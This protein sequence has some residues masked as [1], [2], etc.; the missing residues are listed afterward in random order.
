MGTAKGT[1]MIIGGIILL[2]IT[3]H[4]FLNWI[5]F[6]L[7]PRMIGYGSV[8]DTPLDTPTAPIVIIVSL[9]GLALLIIGVRSV[10]KAKRK[11]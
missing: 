9:V 8:G 5:S 4:T 10:R 1:A 3:V 6:Y 11:N 2:V 7:D